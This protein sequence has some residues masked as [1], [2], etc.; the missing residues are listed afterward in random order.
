M[1][2]NLIQ[3]AVL[4][5]PEIILLGTVCL[6]FL[7]GPFMTGPGLRH[8]WGALSLISLGMAG[9]WSWHSPITTGVTGPF[10]ADNLVWCVRVLVYALGAALVLILWNQTDDQHSAECQACLLSILAGAC[11]TALAND[12]IGLFLG[13]ELVSIPTYI[14]LYLPRRDAGSREA[15]LKYFLLSI[16]SSAFVLYGLTLIYG[17]AGTTDLRLVRDLI[18]SPLAVGGVRSLVMIGIALLIAGLG[19]RI[20]AVPFHFYAPDV[21]QGVPSAPAAMLSFIP[22]VVGFVALLRIVEPVAAPFAA[23]AI[24][25]PALNSAALFGGLAVMTMFVGNLMALRQNNLHRLMAYS[26]VAHAG[27]MLVGMA[28]GE[29]SSALSGRQSLLF[30]LVAYGFMTVGFFAALTAWGT[31][32]GLKTTDDLA[33]LSRRNPLG[34]FILTLF[35]FSLIGL[36][37]TGGFLGK[38]NLFLA[39][40]THDSVNPFGKRLAIIMALNAAIGA[41]Y[42]LRLVAAM[43]LN[44]GDEQATES[45]QLPSGIAACLCAVGTVALFVRPQLVWSLLE[46]VGRS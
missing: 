43:Y 29:T 30:Y 33:G 22:K 40:W 4:I 17:A 25:S 26:S 9:Y 31:E 37:P 14:L 21:F 41:W 10:Q 34:A 36:P 1:Y 3:A 24:V 2:Q 39:A 23:T 12:L 19:F 7:A 5:I 35:L 38:F 27:Y 32:K 11:F 44:S 20:T 13:L 6:M 45:P 8:R 46:T 42:Y 18:T 15:T 16:F 28:L